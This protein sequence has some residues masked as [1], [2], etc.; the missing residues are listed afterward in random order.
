L[1]DRT[2]LFL[3]NHVYNIIIAYTNN[4]FFYWSASRPTVYLN[5]ASL[6]QT[7]SQRQSYLHMYISGFVTELYSNNNTLFTLCDS[8]TNCAAQFFCNVDWCTVLL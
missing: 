8:R 4:K 5:F 2:N 3:S 6:S 1:D 7:Q